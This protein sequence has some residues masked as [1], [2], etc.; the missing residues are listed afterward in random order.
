MIRLAEKEA[1]GSAPRMG[2][3]PLGK[4]ASDTKKTHVRLEAGLK[5]RINAARGS[6]SMAAFIR[7]A[8][9]EKLEREYHG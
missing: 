7:E 2:R 8:A 3:K 5:D 1:A 4:T 9:I 6:V